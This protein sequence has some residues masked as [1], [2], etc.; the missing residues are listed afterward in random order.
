M[1][2]IWKKC[3]SFPNYEVSNTGKMRRAKNGRQIVIT[4]DP[5]NYQVVRIWYMGKKYTKR[6]ARLV[7]EAF[8]EK[9]CEFFIDHIDMDKTNNNIENLRCITP[10]ENSNNRRI[11]RVKNRYDLSPRKKEEIINKVKRQGV[12][13]TSIWREYGLPT[14]YLSVILKRGT[15][16]IYLNESA[17]IQ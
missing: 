16:D 6:I 10:K 14:N 11:Y 2:E 8:N 3:Y 13:L 9:E 5:N 12:S 7:W 17:T 4:T 15:W 1:N